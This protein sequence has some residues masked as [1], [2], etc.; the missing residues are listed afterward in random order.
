M[1]NNV[2]FSRSGTIKRK[3]NYIYSRYKT[4]RK[5]YNATI[6]EFFQNDFYEALTY[7]IM[8]Y[9]D[10]NRPI[11]VRWVEYLRFWIM[12]KPHTL[13]IMQVTTDK[14]IN[15]KE[16]IILAM[17]KISLDNNDV[18]EKYTESPSPDINRMAYLIAAKYNP[19]DYNYAKEVR[20][21]FEQIA[22]TFYDPIP[23]S[24]EEIKHIVINDY[25]AKL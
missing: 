2:Q 15:D 22:S 4:F 17:Q 6:H 12:R 1:L 14:Y 21:I 18:M 11:V 25:S 23:D 9:E 16:S 19:G 5:K 20:E 7:S 24:Y 8:I 13:G 10:F 3:N